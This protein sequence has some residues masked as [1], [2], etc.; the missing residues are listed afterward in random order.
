MKKKLLIL[1]V[2]IIILLIIHKNKIFGGIGEIQTT[3][4]LPIRYNSYDLRCVPKIVDNNNLLDTNEF[5]N[6]PIYNLIG[7]YKCLI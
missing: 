1:L 7:N 3:T 5:N 2:A 6:N 4:S